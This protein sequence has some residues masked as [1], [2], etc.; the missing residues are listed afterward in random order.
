LKEEGKPAPDL[1]VQLARLWLT[2]AVYQKGADI[3]FAKQE[4]SR[5]TMIPLTSIILSPKVESGSPAHR[6]ATLKLVPADV[7]SCGEGT[8]PVKIDS[9]PAE[10]LKRVSPVV[11]LTASAATEWVNQL[12]SG[13]SRSQSDVGYSCKP[14]KWSFGTY[15]VVTTIQGES[16]YTELRNSSM[17]CIDECTDQAILSFN[18]PLPTDDQVE[19]YATQTEALESFRK[20]RG[21]LVNEKSFMQQYVKAF[22]G[23]ISEGEPHE[24]ES[25]INFTYRDR[26][27]RLWNATWEERCC[28]TDQGDFCHAA[29]KI[30]LW[31]PHCARALQVAAH[32]HRLAERETK[33]SVRQPPQE[34]HRALP[35]VPVTELPAT[36]PEMRVPSPMLR[37]TSS[38]E[39]RHGSEDSSNLVGLAGKQTAELSDDCFDFNDLLMPAGRMTK[40]RATPSGYHD[41]SVQQGSQSHIPTLLPTATKYPICN[42]QLE[43]SQS[44]DPIPLPDFSSDEAQIAIDAFFDFDDLF[45]PAC[46]ASMANDFTRSSDNLVDSNAAAAAGIQLCGVD[47]FRAL[48]SH[49][50]IQDQGLPQVGWPLDP[51]AEL[52][53][54]D[55][56]YYASDGTPSGSFTT[57]S[58]QSRIG[59]PQPLLMTNGLDSNAAHSSTLS[60]AGNQ[61]YEL[62]HSVANFGY[63]SGTGIQLELSTQTEA[64]TQ[65]DA[66]D[67]SSFIDSYFPQSIRVWRAGWFGLLVLLFGQS[68]FWYGMQAHYRNNTEEQTPTLWLGENVQNSTLEFAFQA[69]PF[70]PVALTDTL[71]HCQQPLLLKLLLCCVCL[72][73]SVYVKRIDSYFPQ[74]CSI[75]EGDNAQQKAERLK[76]LQEMSVLMQL[77]IAWALIIYEATLQLVKF[78]FEAMAFGV[79]PP[80]F[81]NCARAATYATYLTMLSPSTIYWIY[82]ILRWVVLSTVFPVQMFV[83]LA[84]GGQYVTLCCTV[85]LAAGACTLNIARIHLSGILHDWSVAKQAQE[86]LWVLAWYILASELELAPWL[87]GITASSCAVVYVKIWVARLY[88][89]AT[90]TSNTE[91]QL[92]IHIK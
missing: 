18:F 65:A 3:E 2:V 61:A 41:L 21:E 91:S 39:S 76:R 84:F 73:A 79:D 27:G 62:Y 83:Y 26:Q 34:H 57:G 58:D 45:Q 69:P 74:I 64:S 1:L 22:Q 9:I 59:M 66:L 46:Q 56:W 30:R 44:T 23:Q 49:G 28:L 31:S 71:W 33:V 19:W 55:P 36:P 24:I 43:N 90:M 53:A 92:D 11:A 67:D 15:E 40:R 60:A 42:G 70:V 37:Q 50:A 8:G 63:G 86:L 25:L 78:D 7:S 20:P 5:S 80:N 12:F 35:T 48:H 52:R 4:I 32:F 51:T 16:R 85:N 81:S 68:H 82:D 87:M 89:D 47:G 77:T 10:S 38:P 75:F 13:V 29:R 54:A 14:M 72:L 6:F 88:C 17:R